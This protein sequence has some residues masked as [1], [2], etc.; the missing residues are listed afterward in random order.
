V[1]G[2]TDYNRELAALRGEI[3][4]ANGDDVATLEPDEFESVEGFE[5]VSPELMFTS[6]HEMVV[7]DESII[8][9][10]PR[11][12]GAEEVAN[13]TPSSNEGASRRRRG[14]RGGRRSRGGDSGEK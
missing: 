1:I 5:D 13:G 12:E 4:V 6:E 7:I 3:D 11:L 9:E 2:L 10:E 14:R 8:A